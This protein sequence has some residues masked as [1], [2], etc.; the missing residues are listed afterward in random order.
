MVIPMEYKAT[1][2]EV[3]EGKVS[4]KCTKCGSEFHVPSEKLAEFGA[5]PDVICSDCNA[6]AEAAADLNA[7]KNKEAADA[8]KSA[9][10][11]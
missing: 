11:N 1:G 2:K 5:S 8:V 10:G 9:L 3:E 4:L 6:V 7:D